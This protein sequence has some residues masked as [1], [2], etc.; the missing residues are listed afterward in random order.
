MSCKENVFFGRWYFIEIKS[1]PGR[2]KKG[3]VHIFS[4]LHSLCDMFWKREGIT[5]TTELEKKFYSTHSPRW[6][7][8]EFCEWNKCWTLPRT[9][10]TAVLPALGGACFPLEGIVVCVGIT[11]RVSSPVFRFFW[12]NRWNIIP[13]FRAITYFSTQKTLRWC[14]KVKGRVC[15]WK[16]MLVMILK[17]PPLLVTEA[18]VSPIHWRKRDDRQNTTHRVTYQ[19]G[20]RA[21]FTSVKLL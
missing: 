2:K 17:L 8:W 5:E 3:G 11:Q 20:S 14:E 9:V 19:C 18:S 21:H 13:T 15:G 7:Q 6:C 16:F 10:W 4:L 12:S 1:T